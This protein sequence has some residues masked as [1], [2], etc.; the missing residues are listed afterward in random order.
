M[1]ENE[2]MSY[3]LALTVAGSDSGGGAGIQADLRTF[4][5][6][7]VFG[8]SAITAVTAQ[9]PYE[10]TAIEG[11]KPETVAAQIRAVTSKLA[12]GGIKTGMM[13]SA[14]IVA[15]AALELAKRK[16]QLVID[17]VMVATSGAVLLKPDA[18]A[19]MKQLLLPLADWI[20]PNIPEAEL[21]LGR[22]L[23]G[24]KEFAA[25]AAEL[26][27]LYGANVIV[28][29]GHA[30]GDGRDAVDFVALEDGVYELGS[31][32]I[33]IAQN[34]TA[35]GTGCT[36][37]A[38]L[39]AAFALEME[40]E[41]ALRAAKGF[42]LGSLIEAV[43]IGSGLLGMYPPQESYENKTFLRRRKS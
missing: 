5:A 11:L 30:L 43:E 38:A 40:P 4:A 19:N 41:E 34:S 14:N 35:H 20:T 17:P 18:I 39:A 3:P 37:S 26:S 6:F 9:N 25:A 27:D 13:F 21:L 42:V 22:K 16:A 10:V 31:P 33:D 28:K 36:F 7:G 2:T 1:K 23:T 8:A 32:R 24:A 29:T 12:V 15:A